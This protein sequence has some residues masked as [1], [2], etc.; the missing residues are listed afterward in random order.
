[1]I[2]AKIIGNFAVV[3]HIEDGDVCELA[4]FKRADAVVATEGIS[5]VDGAGRDGL[6]G[7]HA[8]LRAGE[9]EN[10][11]HRKRG[12]GAGIEIGRESDDGAGVDELARGS[13]MCEAEM[14]AAAGKHGA[15]DVGAGEGANVRGA[16]LFEMVGARGVHFD[17]EAGGAGAGELF[18]VKA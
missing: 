3:G 9:G 6:G 10:H 12:A 5:S 8:H 4:N 17:G 16:E 2:H 11:G 18:G 1:M 15:G 14:E 13:V 7:C